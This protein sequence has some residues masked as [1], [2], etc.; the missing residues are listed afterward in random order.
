[1]RKGTLYLIP[2]PISDE[3]GRD[4]LPYNA[5]TVCRLRHFIAESR[6]SAVK[7]L[8]ELNKDFNEGDYDIRELNE[9]TRATELSEITKPLRDGKDVGFLSEAGC[10][11]V[12]DPGNLA[13]R[14]AYSCGARVIP[15]VG[16]SSII[17]S[18][19]AS[20]F[21]G[22]NFAFR[23]YL[24]IKEHAKKAAIKRLEERAIKEKQTQIF[25]ET[26]YRNAALFDSL[27]TTLREETLLCIA[28]NLTGKDERIRMKS[29]R[30]WKKNKDEKPRKTPTIFLLY[31]L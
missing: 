29:I 15:L 21:N 30:E 31:S 10:P 6:R 3:W 19:M 14:E 22:Q 26:P 2:V 18:L 27:L 23:G 4:F 16:A 12:A 28:E 5:Q 9:H 8:S 1:M 11:C 24:P 13:V 25:I 7:Y 20:G 17:L